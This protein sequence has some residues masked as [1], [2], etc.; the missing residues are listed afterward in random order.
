VMKRMLQIVTLGVGI[1]DS[2]WRPG[3]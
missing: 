2:E 1:D 3:S